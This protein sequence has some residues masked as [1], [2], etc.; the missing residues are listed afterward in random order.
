MDYYDKFIL[1]IFPNEEQLLRS[2]FAHAKGI[3]LYSRPLGEAT[4]MR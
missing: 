1:Q 2:M 4:I 3:I